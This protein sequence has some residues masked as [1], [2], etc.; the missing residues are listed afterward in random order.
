MY[1]EQKLAGITTAWSLC[2]LFLHWALVRMQRAAATSINSCAENIYIPLSP[3]HI[4]DASSLAH[5][6]VAYYNP[7]AAGTP[8]TIV[9]GAT[10]LLKI[11]G[12]LASACNVHVFPPVNGQC[13]AWCGPDPCEYM[14]ACRYCV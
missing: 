1:L 14:S 11:R 3:S 10:L 7:S 12:V 4:P 6:D 8:Y 13:L 2:W 9:I 5:R